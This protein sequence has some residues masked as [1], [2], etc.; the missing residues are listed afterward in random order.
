[1]KD[2]T[3]QRLTSYNQVSVGDIIICDTAYRYH[4]LLT[5]GKEYKILSIVPNPFGMYQRDY[6][7]VQSDNPNKEITAHLTRFSKLT[8]S[9]QVNVNN[10]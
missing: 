1:M 3:L 10:P 5:E 7:T 6:V 2:T 8:E 9:E 4:H